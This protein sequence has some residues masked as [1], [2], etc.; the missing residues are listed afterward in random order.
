MPAGSKFIYS[1]PLRDEMNVNHCI[2]F[3]LYIGEHADRALRA[4]TILFSQLTNEYDL[5]LQ[6][7]LII[8]MLTYFQTSI[9]SIKD[10]GAIRIRCILWGSYEFYYHRLQISHSV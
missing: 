3:S 8:T 5:N 10:K 1:R 9:Q 4:K 2:E 6:K 7:C